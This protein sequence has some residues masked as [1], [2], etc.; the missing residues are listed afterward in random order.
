ML[1]F[2]HFSR[3]TILGTRRVPESH[4][5]FGAY[6]VNGCDEDEEGLP[7]ALLR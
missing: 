5:I 2:S 7:T 3:S 1:A 6:I 4:E